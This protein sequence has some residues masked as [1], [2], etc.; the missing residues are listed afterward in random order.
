[1]T[2]SALRPWIAHAL[3]ATF[4]SWP[5]GSVE[6]IAEAYRGVRELFRSDFLRAYPAEFWESEECSFRALQTDAPLQGVL[7]YR[8]SHEIFRNDASDPLLDF[9]AYLMRATTG[10]EVYYSSVIGEGFRIMHGSGL[11]L[12]PRN[13]I[14][15]NF[16]IYQGVTLGQRR[17]QSPDEFLQIGHDCTVFAGARV[18]GKLKL[19]NRVTVGANAVLICDAEEG[20]T[21]AGVPAKRINGS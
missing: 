11:V 9:L 12:G 4:P 16:T 8:V 18:L 20:A 3:Q 21:Y 13:V 6:R 5:D 2:S 10:M 14:G 1:M 15:N 19:G 7:L 17:Q